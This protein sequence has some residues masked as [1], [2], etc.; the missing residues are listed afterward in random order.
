MEEEILVIPEISA[1]YRT[2]EELI[3]EN[4]GHELEYLELVSK[5]PVSMDAATLAFSL[6][7]FLRMSGPLMEKLLLT[8]GEDDPPELMEILK[9][10]GLEL[11]RNQAEKLRHIVVSFKDSEDGEAGPNLV[12]ALQIITIA[13][14][15]PRVILNLGESYKAPNEGWLEEDFGGDEGAWEMVKSIED[16]RW[17][18]R[19]E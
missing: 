14:Q 5:D 6:S 10:K 3:T 15:R 18:Q 2:F 19:E 12:R 7:R 4:S 16:P 9:T 11:D 1:E 17:D 8:L 13:R